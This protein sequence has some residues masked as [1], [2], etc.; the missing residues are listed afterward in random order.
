M[1]KTISC[2]L[3]LAFVASGVFADNQVVERK[4]HHKSFKNVYLG[5]VSFSL[6]AK[7]NVKFLASQDM[8]EKQTMIYGRIKQGLPHAFAEASS[9]TRTEICTSA[10]LD[11]VSPRKLFLD[12]GENM[13][14]NLPLRVHFPGNKDTWPRYCLVVEITEVSDDSSTKEMNASA[15]VP[16]MWVGGRYMGGGGMPPSMI[17]KD[18]KVP[19]ECLH[20]SCK[21]AFIDSFNGALVCYGCVS[22]DGCG[23]AADRYGLTGVW[24]VS[25][26]DLAKQITDD[27]PFQMKELDA[28]DFH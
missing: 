21:Y 10:V 14:L 27:S 16:G 12:H 3:M 4:Y 8:D 18:K 28:S 1:M 13:Y 20:Y 24:A 2:L 9:C 23:R 17:L 15:G 7:L 11:S 19:E 22:A 6:N 5:I 25:L 26:R